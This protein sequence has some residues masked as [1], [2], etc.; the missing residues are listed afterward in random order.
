M[1]LEAASVVLG[2]L[3]GGAAQGLQ[4]SASGAVKDAYQRLRDLVADRLRGNRGAEAALEGYVHDPEVWQRPLEQSLEVSGALADPD[5]LRA[6]HFLLDRLDKT[7]PM[8]RV[9][10]VNDSSG[11]QVNHAD[12][13]VQNNS[14]RP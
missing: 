4:D 11:V 12:G 13:N 9:T 7:G 8:E 2:A 3:A 10:Q 5:L 14:F 6:A 1:E